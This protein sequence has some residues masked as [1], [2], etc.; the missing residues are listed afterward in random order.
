M[1]LLAVQFAQTDEN[2]VNK[3]E[4]FEYVVAPAREMN[5]TACG[6]TLGVPN[7]LS[8]CTGAGL[9]PFLTTTESSER[10]TQGWQH[11]SLSN[12]RAAAELIGPAGMCCVESSI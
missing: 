5:I 4:K 3:K 8:A 12:G 2:L 10:Q 11:N 7:V 1:I 6:R 9:S